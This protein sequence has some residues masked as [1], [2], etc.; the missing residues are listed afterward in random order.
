MEVVEP[1]TSSSVA[2]AQAIRNSAWARMV[3]AFAQMEKS[4][5]RVLI[6]ILVVS[7][8]VLAFMLLGLHLALQ[9]Y[10]PKV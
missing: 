8:S 5:R 6:G 3:L 4:E 10:L 7:T 9:D 2:E 1:A